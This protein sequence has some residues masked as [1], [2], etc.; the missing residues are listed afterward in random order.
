MQQGCLC[1]WLLDVTRFTSEVVHPSAFCPSALVQA[2]GWQCPQGGTL[3]GLLSGPEVLRLPGRQTDPHTTFHAGVGPS[4]PDA[5]TPVAK[6]RPGEKVWYKQH[7]SLGPGRTTHA[8]QLRK[9]CAGGGATRAGRAGPSGK[10]GAEG[11]GRGREEGA[12]PMARGAGR[13]GGVLDLVAAVAAA[14]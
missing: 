14:R 4:L 10:G 12:G 11:E 1:G 6:R 5:G 7:V 3:K 13:A 9:V 8:L 2:P